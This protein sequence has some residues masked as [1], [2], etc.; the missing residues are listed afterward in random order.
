MSADF[1]GCLVK[2]VRN[3]KKMQLTINVSSL[4]PNEKILRLIT[5]IEEIFVRE[6]ISCEIEK[7]N[8]RT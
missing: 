3:G 8:V 2:K 5:E 1:R 6:G 7:K 4:L